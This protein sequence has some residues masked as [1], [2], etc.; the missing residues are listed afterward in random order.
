MTQIVNW[1]GS[2]RSQ[3]QYFEQPEDTVHLQRI[4]RHHASLNRT[5]RGLGAAH[6]SSPIFQTDDCL[7]SLKHFTGLIH[8]DTTCRQ[9]TLGAGTTLDVAGRLLFQHGLALPNVGDI[10]QQSLA[11]V[12]ATGTHGTGGCF[13]NLANMLVGGKLV[14]GEGRLHEFA[15]ETNAEEICSLRVSL[16]ALGLFTELRLQLEPTQWLYRREWCS[17][18]DDFLPHLDAV[19]AENRHVDFYWYPRSDRVK[20]RI[21]NPFDGPQQLS[22][23]KCVERQEGW[24]HEVIAQR[25]DLKFEETEYALPRAVG[26][27]CF[28]QIRERVKR[29]HR[30]HVGWRILFRTVA[31]DEAWLSPHHGRE[32]VT[33]SVLQ[34]ASLPYEDYFRDIETVFQSYDGRPHW[35]KK[36]NQS[37]EQLRSLYPQWQAFAAARLKLDPKGT[38]LNAALRRLLLP[39]D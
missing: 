25:R 24:T 28:L 29:L 21:V 5:I 17:Q 35:G 30:R 15:V 12:I 11:G 32:S 26:L 34:N 3:P 36:H 38:L 33:I 37:A 9:A 18:I 20:L 16:G 39:V 13:T 4:V 1:S 27:A 23:A 19:F 22:Y 2:I 14:T 10:D 31:S 8:V 7:I 6:S